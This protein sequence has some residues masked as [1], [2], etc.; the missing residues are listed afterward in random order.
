VRFTPLTP[1]RLTDELATWIESLLPG[2]T[3]VGIDGAT[4]IGATGLADAVAERLRT[5]GRPVVRASTA[6]WWRPASLRL[7]YGHRDVDMLLTGWVDSGSLRRE[8]LD[9]LG[10]GGSGD[11]LVRLRDPQTD[12][13]LREPRTRAEPGTILVLDGPFLLAADLPLD[14]VVHL[15]VSSATLGR[16]LSPARQ[17]WLT[18]FERYRSEYGPVD[19]AEVVV[20]YDHPSAPAAAWSRYTG[21]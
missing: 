10:S 8:L 11:H 4:E 20:G 7:E 1:D 16:T 14:A 12:R 13:S 15:Q 3:R 9:P 6:W 21:Q 19:K 5:R 17:W 18:G 2:G